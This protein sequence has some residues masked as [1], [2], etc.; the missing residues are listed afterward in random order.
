MEKELPLPGPPRKAIADLIAVMKLPLGWIQF[1]STLKNQHVFNAG[2]Q[3]GNVITF[4]YEAKC[5]DETTASHQLCFYLCS[6]Q[7]QRQAIGF[8]DKQLFGAILNGSILKIY[9]SWWDQDTVVCNMAL[10]SSISSNNNKMIY[11]TQFHLSLAN[12]PEFLT[13]YIF[14][15]KLANHIAQGVNEVFQD[16]DNAD[17]KPR[18]QQ[19]AHRA[20]DNPWYHPKSQTPRPPQR[21]IHYDDGAGGSGAQ[22]ED[23]WESSMMED[24]SGQGPSDAYMAFD[25]MSKSQGDLLTQANLQALGDADLGMVS[26]QPAK[27]IQGWAQHL[28][29][30][31]VDTSVL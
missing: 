8:N 5:N 7:N 3:P 12:F 10:S 28:V 23:D 6:A 11:P 27:D 18:I 31:N 30:A 1:L 25:T 2:L 17:Q 22:D 13:C 16:W 14:L 15:C 21:H 19:R 4:S 9:A 26:V 29:G 20:S 24:S